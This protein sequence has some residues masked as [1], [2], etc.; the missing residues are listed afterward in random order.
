MKHATP[1]TNAP[2][3][4]RRLFLKRSAAAVSAAAVGPL[5]LDPAR[6]AETAPPAAKLPVSRPAAPPAEPAPP[7]TIHPYPRKVAWGRGQLRIRE[8]VTLELGHGVDPATVALLEETWR[9]FTFGAIALEVR[10]VAARN[11]DQFSLA[12]AGLV[13]GPAPGRE[14]PSTYALR[15]DAAGAAATAADPAAL[16]HAWFTL[17][18]LL[19]AGAPPAG[20]TLDFTLPHVAIQDWPALSFRGLHLCIFKETPPLMIE[21]A[22]RLAA[23]F[24][25]THL[26]LEF[27]GMLRLEAQ[28]EL[29][30]PEAWP[31]A[32]AGRLIAIARGMGLEVIPMFNSWGHAAASRMSYGRHV[33]LNQNPRLAP[34]FEPDGWTW[35]LSNPRAQTL[36]RRVCDELIEFAGPGRYFHIGCDEA[37]SHATC[38]RC[39][40]T[41]RV[42]LFADHVNALATHLEGRGRRVIMWGDALLE[43]AKWPRPF[44]ANGTP[45]LPTHEALAQLS[46]RIMIADWHYDV[47]TGELPTLAHFRAN[48]F[49]TMAC[50]WNSLA[51]I[52]TLARAAAANQSGLLMTT[53]HHLV[54]SIPTLAY[55]AACAWSQ[56]QAV[57][58]MAQ[59]VDSSLRRAAT[60]TCLRKLVPADGKFDRAGWNTFEMPAEID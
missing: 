39:R 24:K 19:Q 33:V 37:Y 54:Q 46:R 60:A 40:Q 25:F 56:D 57:L 42:K 59:I 28:K 49:E 5:A 29:S 48:G 20:D 47:T 50:P 22:I 1:A 23:F 30:W 4:S 51:N 11:G 43:R 8:R 2:A 55:T 12:P 36:I 34:L 18:Q 3:T 38:D 44:A 35:C 10:K 52:R 9:Q 14:P 58:A 17:L 26:V 15:V 21:K 6:A 27:W 53:W 45:T 13:A 7:R 32:E 41:D 16:R 31:K